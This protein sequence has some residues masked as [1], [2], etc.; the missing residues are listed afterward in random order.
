MNLISGKHGA[1]GQKA[2]T[3]WVTYWV[4]Y[5]VTYWVTYWV[6]YWVTYWVTYWVIHWVIYTIAIIEMLLQEIRVS[7]CST[8]FSAHNIHLIAEH[9]LTQIS[10]SNLSV[11]QSFVQEN[12]CLGVGLTYIAFIE[13]IHL[14]C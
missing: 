3:Y 2:I 9:S 10:S 11:A 12:G 13:S 8:I 14:S 4:I 1:M 6:I 5:W 7:E